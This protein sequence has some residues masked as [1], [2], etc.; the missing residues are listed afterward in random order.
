MEAQTR[1]I[2]APMEN[3]RDHNRSI[4]LQKNT[5]KLQKTMT[6]PTMTIK[7]LVMAMGIMK[8]PMR[9]IQAKEPNKVVQAVA[10]EPLVETMKV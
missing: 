1:T 6:V 4:A 2:I 10:I 5:T 9:S 8:D 7:A 3:S